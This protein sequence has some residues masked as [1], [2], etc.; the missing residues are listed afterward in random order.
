MRQKDMKLFLSFNME[1]VQYEDTICISIACLL[2]GHTFIADISDWFLYDL[3][4]FNNEKE[5]LQKEFIE[6]INRCGGS[7]D[8]NGH[9]HDKDFKIM[10]CFGTYQYI[11]EKL[12]WWIVKVV[13]DINNLS[14]Y[15]VDI[16]PVGDSL[17]CDISLFNKLIVVKDFKGFEQFNGG[18]LHYNQK[19]I[20]INDLI[21]QQICHG[22][23]NAARNYNREYLLMQFTDCG[24]IQFIRSFDD[25]LSH[26][27]TTDVLFQY[28]YK[29]RKV[30]ISPWI[31]STITQNE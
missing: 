19:G 12:S 21:C 3:E 22:D 14:S 18:N 29:L 23:L 16:V 6:K 15:D 2:E 30:D 7:Y 5:R 27:I 1:Y 17:H 10:Y 25:V 28:F 9:A 26:A 13:N 4:M 20:D 24:Y 8:D 31:L 11:V